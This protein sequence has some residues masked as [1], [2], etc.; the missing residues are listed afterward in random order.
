MLK[1][2]MLFSLNNV[3]ELISILSD[4]TINKSIIDKVLLSDLL[5]LKLMN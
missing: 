3:Y 5:R 4:Y 1:I 2:D